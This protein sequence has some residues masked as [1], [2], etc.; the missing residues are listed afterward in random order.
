MCYESAKVVGEVV[1]YDDTWGSDTA[2]GFT[3]GKWARLIIYCLFPKKTKKRVFKV[4][5]GS[6]LFHHWLLCD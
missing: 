4:G 2:L 3:A 6:Q 1:D 5:R